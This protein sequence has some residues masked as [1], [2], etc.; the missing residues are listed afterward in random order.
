MSVGV[1]RPRWG[2]GLLLVLLAL[3][4]ASHLTWAVRSEPG[5]PPGT[6]RAEVGDAGA[7]TTLAWRE[8]AAAPGDPTVLLLHGSPGRGEDL[9]RIAEALPPEV[10]MLVPDLPGHGASR[11]IPDD[12]GILATSAALESLLESRGLDRVHVLG[13]SLGGAVALELAHRAPERVASLHLLGAMG[14]VEHELLGDPMLNAGL[15]ALGVL[16]ADAAT[17]LLPHFGAGDGLAGL[18]ASM[19]S[20]ADTDQVRL[21]SVLEGLALPTRI[22]HGARDPLVPVAAAKEHAR[23]VPHA[24]LEIWDDASHFLPFTRPREVAH[25]LAGWIARVEAG[26]AASREDAT[27]E[28]LAEATRPLGPD[29][30]PPVTGFALLLTG[31]LLALATLGSE[32]LTCVAAGLLVAD[33]RLSWLFASL[34]CFVGILVGDLLLFAAGRLL[35]R[36]AARVPPLSWMLSEEQLEQASAWFEREGPR[37]IFVSRFLP[38]LRLPTYFS[39][40]VLRT[41]PLRFAFWFTL[42]GLAWTPLL[43]GLSALATA[44]LGLDVRGLEASDLAALGLGVLGLVITLRLALRLATW[45]G[46]RLLLGRW[47]RISR[48]EFWPPW[49]FYAPAVAA[50]CWRWVRAGALLPTAAN[51]AMP[52]GGFVGESKRAILEGLGQ[53]P[54]VPLWLAVARGEDAR[55]RVTAWREDHGLT[56][57][58]VLKPD[59]GERGSA[60]HVLRDEKDLDRRLA[61]VPFEGLLMEYAPGDE[62]GVFW[63]HPPEDEEGRVVAVTIKVLPTVT[64]DGGRTLEQLV[65]AD[66]R[67]VALHATYRRERADRFQ[68]VVPAGEIVTLTDVGTHARGCLF[69]DGEHLITPEL[70]RAVAA[71]TAD[72]QGFHFGRFD[73]KAPSAE[74]LSRGEGLRVIE[75][76]GV[77]SEETQIWDPGYGLLRAWGTQ[78][79]QWRTAFEVGRQCAARGAHVASLTELLRELRAWRAR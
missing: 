34:A 61:E 11:P 7:P 30:L 10:G 2:R 16:A 66:P 53:R 76:N 49:L 60:V 75:L 70:T 78:L 18:R 21:R 14:V 26:T 32:D 5:L 57:P 39:A 25:D 17:W 67:A 44:R 23:L 62:F 77:T 15:H 59:Q 8:R 42:A 55:E 74:H 29:D 64:G 9:G 73:L 48:Y 19:R 37:V 46:R 68:E 12:L 72:Y 54:E 3:L 36:P 65:L 56:L 33:G 35:G 41:N 71:L 28:R 13:W 63:V 4:A 47:H 38:G 51:P 6:S 52:L 27:A 45:R 31:L 40:G 24:E 22:L 1:R 58:L 79:R 20:F 50:F 43:V 69:L